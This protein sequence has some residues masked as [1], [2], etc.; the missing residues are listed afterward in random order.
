MSL[1]DVDYKNLLFTR[2]DGVNVTVKSNLYD[3]NNLEE[4]FLVFDVQNINNQAEYD[5]FYWLNKTKWTLNELTYFAT[6][7]SL[8]MKIMDKDFSFIASYGV[9]P[10][11]NRVFKPFFGINFN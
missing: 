9:C 7:N 3:P 8:C 2:P 5:L 10:V 1:A 11:E 4:P 6:N